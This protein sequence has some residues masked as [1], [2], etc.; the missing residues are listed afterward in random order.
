MHKKKILQ[1]E[2]LWQNYIWL[3]PPA[4][5]RMSHVALISMKI[6]FIRINNLLSSLLMQ[7]LYSNDSTSRDA[8]LYSNDDW[9]EIYLV[10]ERC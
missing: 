8:M 4:F 9:H 7:I 3:D 6:I 2:V 5:V 10:N 1:N